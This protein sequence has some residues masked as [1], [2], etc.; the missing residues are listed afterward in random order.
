MESRSQTHLEQPSTR[1]TGTYHLLVFY[2]KTCKL[3]LIN[4]FDYNSTTSPGGKS[5][6][7]GQT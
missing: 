7:H 4:H 3:G 6:A 5:E 1:H 2:E